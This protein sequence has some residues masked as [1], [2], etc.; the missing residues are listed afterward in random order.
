MSHA[1]PD[2]LDG[3]LVCTCDVVVSQGLISIAHQT[4]TFREE[5][6]IKR[7]KQRRFLRLIS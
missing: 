1:Y 7:R 4:E 2:R 6:S 3:L 5:N